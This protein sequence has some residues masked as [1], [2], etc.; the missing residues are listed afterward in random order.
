MRY[1]PVTG[2]VNS[3]FE[4]L[5]ALEFPTSYTSVAYINVPEERSILPLGVYCKQRLVGFVIYPSELI[6]ILAVGLVFVAP[7]PKW[8]VPPVVNCI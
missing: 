4:V 3:P 5:Y 1:T 2:A 6:F 7:V 8:M